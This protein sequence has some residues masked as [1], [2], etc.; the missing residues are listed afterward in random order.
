MRQGTQA[1][2]SA[3]GS[4]TR[5]LHPLARRWRVIYVNNASTS[6]RERTR[7]ATRAT[8][9]SGPRL[10]AAAQTLI[11]W[12]SPLARLEQCRDRYGNR[13]TIRITSRP[14]HVFLCDPNDI[15]A[16]L[17]APAEALY[18]GEGANTVEPLVGRES[19]M[20]LDEEPH[21]DGRK[22][23]LPQFRAETVAQHTKLIDEVSQRA[24]AL[25]PRDVSVALHPRLRALTLET[26]LR[27][28]LGIPGHDHEP[29]LYELHKRLLAILSVAGYALFSEPLLR[30]GP[31][32]RRW[33]RFL[34]ERTE[35]DD[36]IYDIIK[37]RGRSQTYADSLLDKL[38][39]ARNA[40]NSLMSVQQV[41][42]NLMSILLA[43]HE[44]TAAQLAWAFQ[45]LAHNPAVLD[46]LT[47]EI[48]SGA[49]ESYLT[50]TI[51]EVLR[52]RPVF[53]FAIPRAVKQPIDIGGWTYRPPAYLLACTYL[54]HHNP[55]LYS[56]PEQFRPERFL[57]TRPA[58][59]A[60]LPWGGG[61]KRCPGNHLATLEMKSV[62]RT[63]LATMTIKPA[64]H[65]IEAAH[66]RSVIVVPRAG[67]QVVLHDRRD[68]WG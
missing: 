66:W 5:L 52:H 12:K 13:F 2:V 6:G 57:E 9:P 26:A 16:M 41:R 29:R 63:V 11:L 34:S 23:I 53:L 37:S 30:H 58:A 35:V 49:G 19:F 47:E 68:S 31:G 60:W 59:R 25:W 36:L 54:L 3:G 64:A 10:P 28:T 48:D 1:L 17:S 4:I 67:S 33:R 21:L 56:D 65:T 44:T 55:T 45:L 51:H 27:I 7:R 14:P 62:L 22:I 8:L 61:R 38:L 50:A 42:D 20:L 40:D 39:E 15:K 43:G 46:K 18:P 32:Q 24:V